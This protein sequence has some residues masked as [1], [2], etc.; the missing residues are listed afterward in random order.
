MLNLLL[1]GW[2]RFIANFKFFT[3][4]HQSASRDALFFVCTNIDMKN[5]CYKKFRDL[6]RVIQKTFKVLLERRP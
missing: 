5:K 4:I 3:F 1:K 2:E 6:D